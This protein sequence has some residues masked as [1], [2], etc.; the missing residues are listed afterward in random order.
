MMIRVNMM[1]MMG[2]LMM[3]NNYDEG[4]VDDDDG[5][6][7]DDEVDDDDDVHVDDDDDDR[8]NSG[9][10]RLGIN[11]WERHFSKSLDSSRYNVARS[12]P[13]KHSHLMVKPSNLQWGP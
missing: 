3:M 7:D 8:V 1:T 2:M 5:N 12:K 9:W 11:S 4:N 6:V 10:S 13:T